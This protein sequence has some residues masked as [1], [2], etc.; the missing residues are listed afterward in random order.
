MSRT[1][2]THGSYRIVLDDGR[3]IAVFGPTMTCRGD[4]GRIYAGHNLEEIRTLAE[5]KTGW[6]IAV[7]SV[8]AARGWIVLAVVARGRRYPCTYDEWTGLGRDGTAD[9]WGSPGREPP[10]ER[11]CDLAYSSASGVLKKQHTFDQVEH[12]RGASLA[13]SPSQ[14]AI[15]VVEY[16]SKENLLGLLLVEAFDLPVVAPEVRDGDR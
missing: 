2:E 15:A 13:F 10:P 8:S 14:K 11:V 7:E 16:L 4:G 1:I 12:P 5:A 6:A 3:P 9:L